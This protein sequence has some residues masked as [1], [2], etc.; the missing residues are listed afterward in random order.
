MPKILD[1]TIKTQLSEGEIGLSSFIVLINSAQIFSVN[2]DQAELALRAL[3]LSNYRLANIEDRSQLLALLNGL[4]TV[5]S[6]ARSCALADEIRIHVRKYIRD[7]Q[8]ALSLEEAIMICLVTS[9]SH[10][11]LNEW[12]DCVGDWLME[13]AFGDIEE[14]EGKV[15]HSHLLYLCHIVPE[16]WI[17][18]GRADAVLV[19]YNGRNY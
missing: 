14:S 17:S 11:G 5:A 18:S 9:S 2:A 13:L 19:A 4:A 15:L 16:L 8:Y 7:T 6:I 3:K 10:V 1:E 12:R